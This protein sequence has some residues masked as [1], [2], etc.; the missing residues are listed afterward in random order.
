M[1]VSG[2]VWYLFSVH[3][4]KGGFRSNSLVSR[5]L[6]MSGLDTPGIGGPGMSV[7]NDKSV[8]GLVDAVSILLVQE[9]WWRVPRI[10]ASTASIQKGLDVYTT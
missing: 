3:G 7:R 5:I 9:R 8:W 10:V 6:T 1:W 2:G 4:Q